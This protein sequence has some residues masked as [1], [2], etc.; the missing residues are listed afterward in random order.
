MGAILG[1]KRPGRRSL[2]GAGDETSQ[3]VEFAAGTRERRL[4]TLRYCPT[5]PATPAVGSWLASS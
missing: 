2:Q 3:E 4:P 5:M 1:L